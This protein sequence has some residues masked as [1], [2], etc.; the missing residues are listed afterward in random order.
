MLIVVDIGSQQGTILKVIFEV[1]RCKV[2]QSSVSVHLRAGFCEVKYCDG[3]LLLLLLLFSLYASQDRTSCS[4]CG[5]FLSTKDFFEKQ[6]I[7]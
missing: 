2:T 7:S 4:R 5:Y 6:C 1:K 3:L